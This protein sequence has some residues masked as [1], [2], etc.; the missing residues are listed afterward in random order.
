MDCC[1]PSAPTSP[2]SDGW[3]CDITFEVVVVLSE[4]T[5]RGIEDCIEDSE[6]V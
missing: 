2:A 6:A 5:G 3:N 1:L 4:V